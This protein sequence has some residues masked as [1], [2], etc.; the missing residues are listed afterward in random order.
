VTT[1]RVRA[2]AH[3]ITANATTAYDKARAI[4]TWL[5]AHTQ[6][7]L[8]IPPLPKGK[9]AVDQYVFVDRKGFC[10]QIGTSLV[11]MLRE[12]GIPAR[13]AVGYTPGERNPFTGLYEV[14]AS[15]A[16]A[17]AEVYFPGVGWQGFDPTAHVP[18]AG[19]AH[20]DAAGDGALSYLSS[21]LHIPT[22][23]LVGISIAGGLIGLVFAFRSVR[24]RPR[25]L[26]ISRSWA[27]TR[28]ARL[29]AL[30]ARRGR[31][32]APSESTPHFVKALGTLA[33]GREIDLERVG[34]TI[35]AAMF[36]ADWTSH[37]HPEDL[38]PTH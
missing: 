9:D 35:D 10:E 3:R 22:E 34:T 11:V 2:L 25:R 24:Q 17:W 32:R 15:D 36:E 18:L 14:K 12:L 5:G 30:G 38:V 13:L 33:T 23:L 29:E 27:S 7:S 1:E 21:R 4:E 20:I 37:G 8:N 19:D 6:Y 16:H 31:P 28:L 26:A